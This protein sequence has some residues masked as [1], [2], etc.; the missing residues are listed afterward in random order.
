MVKITKLLNIQGN[1]VMALM[2]AIQVTPWIQQTEFK[3]EIRGSN[4]A[5]LT[6][7]QCPTLNS[8]EREGEGR[9]NLVCKVA[10]PKM[11]E[12]YGKIP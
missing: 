2:K 8:L 12:G 10:V 11:F 4:S 9:E 7:T 5:T 6:I 1:D 3:M